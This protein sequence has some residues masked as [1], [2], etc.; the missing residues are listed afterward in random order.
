MS[1]I[2]TR[3]TTNLQNEL[4]ALRLQVTQLESETPEDKHKRLCAEKNA[5]IEQ[6]KAQVDAVREE[7]QHMQ[8][9]TKK[10]EEKLKRLKIELEK[11]QP[12]KK[13]EKLEFVM[14]EAKGKKGKK[15]RDA[16]EGEM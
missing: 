4:A 15:S 12:K 6:L 10:G 8:K 13:E 7:D 3:E 16:T 9:E 11:V 2:V 5:R 14:R 1:A